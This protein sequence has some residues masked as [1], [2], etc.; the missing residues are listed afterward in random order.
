MTRQEPPP[1]IRPGALLRHGLSRGALLVL[2]PVVLAAQ[3]IAWLAYAVSGIYRPWSWL[4]IGLA[5]ALGS[6]R[7][8]FDVVAQADGTVVDSR[9]VVAFG[10]L[11]ILVLVLAYRAGAMQG[12]GLEDRPSRAAMA[13]ALIAPGFALPLWAASFLVVLRFP[14][15][16]VDR[17]APDP[18]L[19]LVLPLVATGVA[20]GVGGLFAARAALDARGGWRATCA[21]AAR[22]AGTML[23]WGLALAFLAFLLLAAVHLDQTRAYARFV[24][25]GTGGAVAVLHHAL[26]LPNQSAMLL[27]VFAGSP[28]EVA[29]GRAAVEIGFDRITDPRGILFLGGVDFPDWFVAF[30]SVPFAAAFLGGRAA[31]T[32]VKRR[33]ALTRAVLGGLGLAALGGLTAWAASIEIPILAAFDASLT[34]GND[35]WR[36]ALVLLPFG[37]VGGAAGAWWSTR[38]PRT[39]G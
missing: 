23:A 6:V 14:N 39:S 8:P 38:T 1:D 3:A 11:T 2:L 13:G 37:L 15:L 19:A 33:E 5:Y 24:G 34:L 36:T 35:P 17:L 31:A 27:G 20:G 29:I 30:V 22:T 4:K 10:A 12:R 25:S 7:V 28:A 18:V 9:L 16:D 21:G 32:D 26:L